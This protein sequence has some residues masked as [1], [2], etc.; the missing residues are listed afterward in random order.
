MPFIN[1]LYTAAGLEN[2]EAYAN[3]AADNLITNASWVTFASI[4]GAGGTLGLC[5]IMCFMAKSTRYKTLGKLASSG[6]CG[7]NE[8][9]T[10]GLP[11]VLNTIMII[12]LIITPITTF[13]ISYILINIGVI[14]P[15]NGTTI[16]LGT[17]VVFGGLVA[18]GW[19]VAILQVALIAV[20]I[21]IYL[22]FFKALDRQAVLEEKETD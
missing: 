6:L 15:L 16:P 17:P 3:G 11:M 2:L 22:P 10:F 13:L 12:P 4:G 9:I 5:I 1:V 14:P 21:L 18:G 7:I 8:P 19:K 20:Q